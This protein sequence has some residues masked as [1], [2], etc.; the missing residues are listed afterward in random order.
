MHVIL[1]SGG[2]IATPLAHDLAGYAEHVRCVSR[3]PHPLPSA[4]GAPPSVAYEHVAAD[5]LS[6]D[7]VRAA[8][9]GASTV[10]LTAGL[11]YDTR[12][13]REQWP[14]VVAN[15]LAACEAV[16]ARLAFF[17]NAYAY[18]PAGYARLTEDTPLDPDSQK[19]AVRKAVRD[20]L[21]DAHAAGRVPV[22][23]AV[24][25]DFYGPGVA[26]SLLLELVAK[27]I[28]A[29]NT[30]Q[31]L[32]DPDLPH[33]FTYTLDA[34]RD[35]ARLAADERAYGEVWHL[36]TVAEPWSARTWAQRFGERLGGPTGV[37]RLP[38]WLWW[39]VA[40]VN[41]PL[42]ELYD[43]RAQVLAPFVFDSSKF[44]RAFGAAP[45]PH[46]EGLAAVCAALSAG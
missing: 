33:S 10:Y 37:A 39:S 29:G 13:W 42:R 21:L 46:A 34:A 45:T 41:R 44:E 40:R 28:A 14:V 4:A 1:G 8:C 30:A 36:P 22:A 6:A 2:A 17:D 9:V 25:A 16:G 5:L 18:S 3:S 32:G 26:N 43:V 24:A 27:R 35:F 23:I 20:T 12:V 15:V 11:A 7:A 31:W 38:R 19:G